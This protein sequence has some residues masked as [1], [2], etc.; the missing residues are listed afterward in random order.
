MG[1]PQAHHMVKSILGTILTAQAWGSGQA[2]LAAKGGPRLQAHAPVYSGPD[3]Q[4][5]VLTPDGNRA[6]VSLDRLESLLAPTLFCL[7]GRPAI[8]SPVRREYAEPLLGHS[9]QGSL[10]P[11]ASASL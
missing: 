5:I 11:Q 8:M 9:L 10:L 6:H 4:L 3:Q 2:M 1:A 7:P